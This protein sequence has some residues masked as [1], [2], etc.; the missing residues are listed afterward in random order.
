MDYCR[1]QML[2]FMESYD[3]ILRPVNAL[4]A[5][6][7]LSE[8]DEDLRP[9]SYAMTHNLTG[10]PGAV[11]RGGTSPEGLSRSLLAHGGKT[12]RWQSRGCWSVS[13]EAFRRPPSSRINKF[14][15]PLEARAKRPALRDLVSLD[16]AGQESPGDFDSNRRAI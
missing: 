14:L 13:S 1:S 12:S 7:H 10:W 2:S 4:P 6:Q 8:D 15:W 11:V 3:V 5:T 16:V 9:F